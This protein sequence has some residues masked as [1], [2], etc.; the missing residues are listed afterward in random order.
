MARRRKR[1]LTYS[2]LLYAADTSDNEAAR[3]AL[4]RYRKLQE[5]GKDPE[6]FYS[7]FDGGYLVRDPLD[8]QLSRK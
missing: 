1:Q 4:K 7:E 3:E 5:E 6:I 8:H 2:E